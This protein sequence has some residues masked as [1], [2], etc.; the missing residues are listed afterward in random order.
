MA[1]K[2]MAYDHPAYLSRYSVTPD[3][4]GGGATTNGARFVAF[5]AMKLKSMQLTVTTAG[6]ATDHTVSGNRIAAGGTTTTALSTTTLGTN[7]VGYTTNVLLNQTLTQGDVVM[8]RTG[9]DAVGRMVVAYEVELVPGA[10][11]TE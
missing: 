3:S 1:T 6:T 4:A 10:N 2:N 11:V 9:S 7:T 8:L 5:T